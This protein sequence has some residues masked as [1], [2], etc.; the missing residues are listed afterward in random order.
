ML[1]GISQQFLI[2]FIGMPV[3]PTV[4]MDV[5]SYIFSLVVV[6]SILHLTCTVHLLTTLTL[7]P[8]S[9]WKLT[10]LPRIC[11]LA[12]SFAP[13]LLFSL[14]AFTV[15]DVSTHTVSTHS[16]PSESSGVSIVTGVFAIFY[17]SRA[18]FVLLP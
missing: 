14:V 13:E 8:V 10:T 3:F 12:N 5:L 2:F 16:Y 15:S 18:C 4:V 9:I 17:S 11:I 1:R 7:A 6:G